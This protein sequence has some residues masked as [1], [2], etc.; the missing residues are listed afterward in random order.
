MTQYRDRI[1]LPPPD[2]QRTNMTCHFCIVGCGYQV[3]KWPENR[4]GGRAPEENAL[5]LD[6][7]KQLP[8]LSII[9]TPP[10][11]NVVTDRDG[12]RHHIMILPDKECVVNQ[13]LSS[14]RGGQMAS[15][16]FTG[17]GPSRQRLYYPMLFTGDDWV[18]TNWDQALQV[19][20]G[21][22]KR[23]LDA[24]GP[25]QIAFDAFD[26]GGAGG[27]FENTWGSGKL[28]FSAIQTPL[29][30]IHNRPA[31]NS[32]CHATRDMGIGELNNSY[33]DSELAD[34]LFYIGA[35][36]YETQTNYFL[37]HALPNMTGK[38]L[39]KKKQW[40]PGES[41]APA[42][43]IFVDPRRSL[44]ISVA[45][46]LA[47]KD[48][49]LHLAIQPGTDTA[50]F[51]GLM[52]YVVEQ[53]W[54]HERFIRDHTSGFEEALKA[55]RM[56]LADCSRITGVDEAD[57]VK[58]AEWAYKP[59]ASR[60]YPRTMHGYEKG[61]IWGNDNYRIQSALVDLVLTTENVGR[62]GSGVVRMGG[63]QEGYARPPYPGGRP[64]RYVDQE[65]IQGR[66]KMLTVWA[67][68]PFQ[69]TLNA[70]QFREA[71]HRRSAIVRDVISKARGASATDLVD[72]IFDAVENRGGLFVVDID[73]Y[74]TK[75]SDAAHLL[76]PATHPGE[77]NLTAMNGERR[78]RLSE[79]FMDPPGEAKPDCLIAA[80]IAN[81]L[82]AL[83]AQEGN[84]E[85]AARFGGFDWT[86]EEDAF[87]DGFRKP[88]GIDSQ[89]G[90]TGD[91]ATYE[92]LRAMGTN[93]VQLPIKE[94]TG[95]KLVGTEMLYTDYRFDTQ[96]GRAHF[97]PAP[98]NGLPG[99]VET[100]RKKHRFWV[101]NGR[102]NH[103]WQTAY[104]DRY[105]AFRRDRFPM[106]P[107]EM[108]PDDAASLGIVSGDIV[109]LHNDYGAAFA[110][111]YLEPDIAPGQSFMMFGYDNGVVGDVVTDWTDR[112]L[113]PY[114]KGTW[115]DIRKV[116]T[117]KDYKRTVSFKRRRFL[118]A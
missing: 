11:H 17:E 84:T 94:F 33:E 113:V 101:N 103:I 58:A 41:V 68:N 30:R 55:N 24:N 85:M 15:V 59:K 20:A 62:R 9:M 16:M 1:P 117:M 51:N 28:M 102:T 54:H 29:V 46:H 80:E 34:T 98:W 74:H 4:E 89:G 70:E 107:L 53:D 21:V 118:N 7:R 22:T 39:E 52:T 31:Y 71:V 18:E 27:G 63:H 87:N 99:T 77:M 6:F 91:L 5:G 92:R 96:D 40:F 49:V 65:I 45:E 64:A 3:Y 90:P 111:A 8:A 66:A 88:E 67:T 50:L 14:T 23:I 93:G 35:N 83:Y 108:N 78:M 109:E 36:G 114:Y 12:S 47:G 19:Y 104:H 56:S 81:T 10:M 60:H 106:S 42:K 72:L 110:M 79:R 100:Q 25:D 112:N 73:L 38:N 97:L 44:T 61:I 57:I 116:G 26:H 48:N 115:A 76:L 75:L 37:A 105:L 43:V 82:K 32:E 69:S 95:G 13:G 2:A 86:T